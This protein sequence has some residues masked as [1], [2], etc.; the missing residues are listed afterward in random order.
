MK[1][2]VIAETTA[3]ELGAIDRIEMCKPHGLTAD[4]LAQVANFIS[5]DWRTAAKWVANEG[6]GRR[7]M[8][9]EA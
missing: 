8:T 1:H 4:T 5:D 2:Y 9:F 6:H 7:W 3:R